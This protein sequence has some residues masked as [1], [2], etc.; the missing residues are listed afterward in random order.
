VSDRE[1]ADKDTDIEFDF[2]DDEPAERT[3]AADVAPPA[4]RRRIPS[5]GPPAGGGRGLLR[6]AILIGAAILLAVILVLWVDS[7]REGKK[8]AEYSDYMG[9]V[10]AIAADSEAIGRELAGLITT[11]GIRL[12]DLQS[13]L[14]G[15]RQQQSQG[16]A[17]AR[18]LQPPGP[19]REQQQ[20]FAE[21]LEFRVSGLNG[22]AQALG[23]IEQAPNASTAG[24]LLASQADRLLTSDVV[25]EDLFV[26]GSKTVLQ[27]EGITGVAVPDSNVIPAGNADL[28]SRRSMTLLVRRLTEGPT[29]GGLHGNQIVGVRV[30]PGRQTLSPSEENTVT[31]SDRLAF[32]V[33]VKNSGDNQETQVTVTLTVQL[34]PQPITKEQAIDFINPGDTKVVTFRNINISGSFG[35]LVT[36]KVTVEPVAGEA[37]TSNNSAQYSVIFTLG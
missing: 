12:A 1:R 7:C 21:A 17:Q 3:S 35:T 13:G 14:E 9:S 27:Q 22:L 33:L 2:F 25:Y 16:V 20:S 10:S 11:P 37:N 19:L 8:K 23:Q 4:R 18:E 31:A 29:G 5:A 34:S 36:L 15:L 30:Q 24:A 32:Q 26:A 28:F 6:L